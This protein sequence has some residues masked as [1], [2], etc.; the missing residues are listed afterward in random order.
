MVL[1]DLV[2]RLMPDKLGEFRKAMRK[3]QNFA[4]HADRDPNEEIDVK[5]ELTV[6][7]LFQA[8]TDLGVA[9]ERQT[10]RQ[11]IFKTWFFAR[12]WER[13]PPEHR[14]EIQAARDIFPG[15][16][17]M[18]LD[19]ALNDL[20]TKILDLDAADLRE[21]FDLRTSGQR[22]DWDAAVWKPEI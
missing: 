2:A 7:T 6:V 20:R 18:S 3:P 13:W 9:F 5:P 21:R 22:I 1:D 11:V 19:E 12:N 10:F 4:K 8:L 14:A 15:V 16:D 17:V